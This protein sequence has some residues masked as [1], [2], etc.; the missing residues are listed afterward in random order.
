MNQDESTFRAFVARNESRIESIEQRRNDNEMITNINEIV[1]GS[2]LRRHP[3]FGTTFCSIAERFMKHIGHALF[4]HLIDKA[5][6]QKMAPD[7]IL[8]I[9]SFLRIKYQNFKVI[10]NPHVPIP[11]RFDIEFNQMVHH[12]RG[13]YH[14]NGEYDLFFDN[15]TNLFGTIYTEE[16]EI[17]GIDNFGRFINITKKGE[18]DV[19]DLLR[20]MRNIE[21]KNIEDPSQNR[22]TMKQILEQ[23]PNLSRGFLSHIMKLQ[24]ADVDDSKR[25][26][27]DTEYYEI[28]ESIATI[29]ATIHR[30]KLIAH[31]PNMSADIFELNVRDIIKGLS[32]S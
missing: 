8:L 19:Q 10:M 20:Q 25:E 9:D 3:N 2:E 16:D 30:S 5:T 4:I 15:S 21:T 31:T 17:E 24:N 23:F 7:V 11:L 14:F 27:L 18:K 6:K 28:C 32:I 22:K 13:T 12:K 29:A 26:D 1:N